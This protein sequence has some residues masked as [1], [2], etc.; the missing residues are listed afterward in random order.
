MA[1]TAN[2]PI[3]VIGG[4][5]MGLSIAHELAQKGQDVEVLSRKRSEAAGFV[6]AGMLAPH[7]E[8]LEGELLK[9]G[10]IS[11]KIIPNAG[12]CPHDEMP[13][14]VN[15]IIKKIIQDAI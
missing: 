15:P 12:H 13:E 8:G 6:A 10:L 9:L 7:S 4:G 1:I 14:K 3:L 5:L 2:K 11:L